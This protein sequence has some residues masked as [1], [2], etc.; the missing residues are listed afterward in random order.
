MED[1]RPLCS[2]CLR[3]DAAAKLHKYEPLLFGRH[4]VEHEKRKNRVLVVE[5]DRDMTNTG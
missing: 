2:R 1:G 3:A 5:M 4:T